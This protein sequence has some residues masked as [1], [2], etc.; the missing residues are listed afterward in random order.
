MELDWVQGIERNGWISLREGECLES[1]DRLS[2]G[3]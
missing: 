3:H 1:G 2:M